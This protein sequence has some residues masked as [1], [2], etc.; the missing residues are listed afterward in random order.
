ML[1][2]GHSVKMEVTKLYLQHDLKSIEEKLYM[3]INCPL[4]YRI[5]FYISHFFLIQGGNKS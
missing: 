3:H 2:K 5:F 4:G 1:D